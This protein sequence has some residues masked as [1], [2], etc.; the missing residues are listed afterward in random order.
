LHYAESP[1]AP[2]RRRHY[3]YSGSSQ[4]LG[5]PYGEKQA[6]DEAMQDGYALHRHTQDVCWLRP[7]GADPGDAPPR[8][9]GE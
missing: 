1:K 8:A 3:P 6:G 7:A 9:S 4:Y 2:A 5:Q